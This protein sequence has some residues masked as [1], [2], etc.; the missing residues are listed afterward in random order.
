MGCGEPQGEFWP[1]TWIRVE[2]PPHMLLGSRSHTLCGS[3]SAL[4]EKALPFS[5]VI[6]GLSPPHHRHLALRALDPPCLSGVVKSCPAALFPLLCPLLGMPCGYINPNPSSLGSPSCCPLEHSQT[7]LPNPKVLGPIWPA[8]PH[9]P[10]VFS[11]Q[12]L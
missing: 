3:P 10:S 7:A 1:V 4:G 8:V 11:Q 5:L 6:P 2:T 9:P 12:L